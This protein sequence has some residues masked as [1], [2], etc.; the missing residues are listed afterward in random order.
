MSVSENFLGFPVCMAQTE[1]MFI[2]ITLYVIVNTKQILLKTMFKL[3]SQ[4]LF[5]KHQKKKQLFTTLCL[6]LQLILQTITKIGNQ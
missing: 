4:N 6:K 1:K 2:Q 3:K 5:E